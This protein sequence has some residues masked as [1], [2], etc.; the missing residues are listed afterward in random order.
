MQEQK[1]RSL[2][3]DQ[4]RGFSVVLMIIFHFSY[5]LRLFDLLS[6]QKSQEWYWWG[7][8]RVIVFLFLF[9]MGMSIAL[10]AK[11]K[12]NWPKFNRRLL[13]ITLGALIVSASTYFLFPDR[14]VYFGTL[15]CIAL[16]SL[17]ILPLRKFLTSN[18]I[19]GVGLFAL[20]GFGVH[21]PFWR[22]PHASMDYISPF[23]WFGAV[24]L[25]VYATHQGLANLSLPEVK[26][27]RPFLQLCL[28]LGRHSLV[29]YLVHQIPLYGLVWLMSKFL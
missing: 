24:C 16:T 7:F 4:L 1:K 5:N 29:I 26:A 25:G 20:H 27:L 2:I 3:V 14:W 19:L 18:L 22:L 6:Y 11:E 15:H 8:P 9:T 23:P 28:S 13:K 17:M 12:I 21:L 10:A